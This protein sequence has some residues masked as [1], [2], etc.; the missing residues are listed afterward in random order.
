ME[1]RGTKKKLEGGVE[2]KKYQQGKWGNADGL[3]EKQRG[4]KGIKK[5]RSKEREDQ[6]RGK[7]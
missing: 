1:D 6:E 3:G 2:K 5:L 7:S 4:E